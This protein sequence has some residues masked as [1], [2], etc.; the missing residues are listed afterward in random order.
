MLSAGDIALIGLKADN[1]DD[2]SFVA[3]TNIPAGE[4]I[5]FT[6]NGVQSD[7]N[8]R[9]NEGTL[10]WIA[11]AEVAAGSVISLIANADQFE[12]V[13]GGFALS[14][15]GD[16]VIAYQDNA[17]TPNFLFALHSNGAGFEGDATSSNTSA[18]PTGL[19]LGDTAVAIPE[20]DN[21]TYKGPILGTA[22]VLRAAIGDASNWVADNS[23]YTA[24]PSLFLLESDAPALPNLQ[25][26]EIWPGQSG[27]GVTEDWFEI[28]NVGD[29]AYD[30][31]IHGV[32]Y[33]DDESADPEAADPVEGIDTLAPGGTAIV[34]VGGAAQAAA[35]TAV[36]GS[37]IDLEGVQ[38]GYTDGAGLGG[39]G[40]AVNLWLGDPTAEGRLLDSE[41]YPDT[42]SNNGASYDVEAGA[43]SAEGVNGA[44][45]SDVTGGD[46]VPAIGSPGNGDAI[47]GPASDFTLE[48][49]HFA[50]QEAGIPA[51]EDAPNFSAVLNALKAQDVGLDGVEDNT[52]ILSS[53]D[54]IIPGVFFDA[55][56]GVYGDAGR[57][58]ILIQNE[59]G[60]QAIALGNHE[61]DKGTADLAGLIAA[62]EGYEGALFPY[63]ST[64]LDVSTDANL[65]PLEVA[66]GGCTASELCHLIRSDRNWPYG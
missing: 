11:P 13:S 43:F 36:W 33:Y 30:A 49:F 28:Q 3:L 66:G 46:N 4:E 9:D 58:D 34:V 1:P 24:P 20:A 8:F 7:G 10:R 6:D 55:S 38:I 35:F 39:G 27:V 31:S 50:D 63:L 51:L 12:A 54:A 57:A 22:A 45:A 21:I 64:N 32:L 48:L 53:G 29:V 60:V 65:A 17:G 18:V 37:V 56:E 15:S 23:T 5:L 14:A 62:D 61:F 59:L 47:E 19:V 42:G 41:A 2:F 16:Q 25:I 26:T 44:V 40:D 52:L